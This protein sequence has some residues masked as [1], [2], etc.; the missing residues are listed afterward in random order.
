VCMIGCPTG[1]I[2]RHTESGVIQIQESICVGC[3]VCANSCPYQN[4]RM[5]PISDTEG[6]PYRD[7]K[8]GLPILK[9]TKCDMCQSQPSGP[10]CV[11]ACPHDALVRI[12]L[13]QTEPLQFWLDKRT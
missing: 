11:S 9:A 2:H 8:S 6:R 4:I 1:A 10:A 12:D 3:S 13:T 7:Q 5:T